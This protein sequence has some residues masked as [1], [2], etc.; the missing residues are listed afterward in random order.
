MNEST[1][2]KILKKL[3][4][5]NNIEL[6]SIVSIPRS[7]STAFSRSISQG[8]D[9]FF[10]NEPF[11]R[12]ELDMEKG[13]KSI[14]EAYFKFKNTRGNKKS[15]IIIKN[16]A[17]NLS[18][19]MYSGLMR[20]SNYTFFTIRDP[21]IQI[22]SLIT[23]VANDIQNGDGTDF[24]DQK[25]L[26]R[27]QITKACMFLESSPVSSNFSKAGW[28]AIYEHFKSTNNS[29]K[30]TIEGDEFIN[31]PSHVIIKACNLARIAFDSDKMIL[32]WEKNY[33]N[34]NTGY[35]VRIPDENHA[36]TKEAFSNNVVI[37]KKSRTPIDLSLYT[38]GL[39]NYISNVAAPIYDSM[40][41]K[42]ND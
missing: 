21:A 36:W 32:G 35:G 23:R 13:C 39:R 26:T 20:L 30:S 3:V 37:N 9:S 29:N 24:I 12:Q 11:N 40:L 6:I 1:S 8:R 41:E 27:Q 18:G 34:A 15:T 2:F 16:M 10:I 14:L 25:K 7:V 28:E 19:E 42:K 38:E 5:S 31:N 17:R 4:D 22:S 33:I